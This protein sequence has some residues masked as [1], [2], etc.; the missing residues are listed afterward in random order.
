MH[1]NKSGILLS[2]GMDSI[3]LAYWRKPSYSFT[4]N[5]GQRAALAEIQAAAQVSNFLGIEHHIIEVDCSK[6]GSGDMSGT[7]PL[8]V[9][10]ISEWWPFRNQLL[11]TL[12]CMKGV[13]LGINELLVGSVKTDSS[14][15]DGTAEFYSRLSSLMSFQEGNIIVS[16]PSIEM[17][18]KELI[19][20]SGIPESILLWAHSCHTSNSPCMNCNG[21]SKY[22]STLQELGLD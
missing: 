17:T 19:E 15:K 3:A 9:S 13:E 4:L 12:A 10:P 22:L 11:V 14:H 2:G 18:T 5:Y 7:E 16:C 21:C 8:S 1:Q 20:E 6:L